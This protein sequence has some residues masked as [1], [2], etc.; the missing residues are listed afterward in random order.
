MKY[1]PATITHGY[2]NVM[3]FLRADYAERLVSNW[4]TVGAKAAIAE[5][6]PEL[7]IKTLA[8]LRV[9]SGHGRYISIWVAA[10]H[11]LACARRLVVA[12]DREVIYHLEGKEVARFDMVEGRA[13][14]K[15][16]KSCAV[17][18]A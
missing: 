14:L 3:G 11:A 13:A 2:Y 16:H 5:E 18:A 15:P 9:V 8:E 12:F 6:A 4:A 7:D 10:K 1:V 17:L